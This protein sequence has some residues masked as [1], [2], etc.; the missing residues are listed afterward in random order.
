MLYKNSD[1]LQGGAMC[2]YGVKRNRINF[3]H[4]FLFK[5]TILLTENGSAIT[6]QK[7]GKSG[8]Y[9]QHVNDVEKFQ[10][11]QFFITNMTM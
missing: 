10:E 6:V 9:T 2:S 5:F 8:V 1:I 3:L 7:L 11:E 4:Y